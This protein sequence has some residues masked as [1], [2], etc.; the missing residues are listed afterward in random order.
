[1]NIEPLNW[2]VVIAGYWN[3]AILTPAGIAYRLFKKPKEIPVQVE[4][5]LD[6]LAPYRVKDGSIVVIGE[7]TRLFIS[8]EPPSYE[9]LQRALEIA[10][11]ALKELP[12]TP[13]LA[14]GFNIAYQIEDISEIILKYITSE[15]DE[16]L[17]D[18]DYR[19]ATRTL[20][21]SIK[22]QQGEINL[23]IKS[24]EQSLGKIS[25]NFEK[26]SNKVNDLVEWVSIPLE[27]IKTTTQ[28]ILEKVLMLP[29]E[30]ANHE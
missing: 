16:A 6:G 19:I 3:Q 1:M 14:A 24:D 18:K 9:N 17:S 30:E 15:I 25:L 10:Q 2:S 27:T 13:V 23:E 22:W 26:R 8:T 11:I 7:P 20:R 5:P 29:A 21:R 28:E 4:V 12:E